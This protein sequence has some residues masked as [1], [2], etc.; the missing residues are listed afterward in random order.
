M[1]R[2]PIP[3]IGHPRGPERHRWLRSD[4]TP[5][6][7]DRI[8]RKTEDMEVLAKKP[9][10][11]VSSSTPILEALE[12]MSR[13]YRSLIVVKGQGFLEGLIVLMDMINYLGGGEYYNIVVNRHGRNIYSAVRNEPVETIMNR[14]PIVAYID[15]KFPQ[16]LEK[17]VLHGIGILPVVTRDNQVYGI[18]TEK[19]V[20]DYLSATSFV[21][22]KVSEVMSSP[23][24]TVSSSDPLKKAM[25]TMVKYGF[26]RLPVTRDNTV[27][28]LIAAMN[29]VKFF[30]SHEAF[31]YTVSG[32]IEEVLRISVSDIMVRGVVTVSPDI[33]VGEAAGL[34]ASKG[35]GSVLVVNENNEL[36]GIVSER[37]ILY[38]I[39]SSR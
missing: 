10:E 34:M 25:E 33:D 2:G 26:R 8:Y 3:R 35:V 38:A 6:F 4:G 37:D 32:D 9:V 18:I 20:L 5:N 19:D 11:T 17:M 22:I 16:V 31:K 1:R 15:E 13:G 24:V 23:V 14:D 27:E 12:K 21:G 39:A 36:V 29:I 28:G 7:S 30:G